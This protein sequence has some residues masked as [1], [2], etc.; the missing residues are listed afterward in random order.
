MEELLDGPFEIRKM[1]SGIYEVV[2]QL[3][4]FVEADELKFFSFEKADL[5][6]YLKSVSGEFR[7]DKVRIRWYVGTG[8]S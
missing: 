7:K 3:Y 5:D 1:L 2:E 8:K 4:P 6:Q